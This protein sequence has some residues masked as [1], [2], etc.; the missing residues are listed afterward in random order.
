MPSPQCFKVPAYGA[1][2]AVFNGLARMEIERRAP[3]GDEVAIEILYC[4]VCHS[5]LHQAKNEWKNTIYPCVPGHEIVGR[6]ARVARGVKHFKTGDLVGVGCMIDSCGRCPSCRNGEENFCE[7]ETSFTGTYNGYTVPDGSGFNTFGGYS[8]HIV[9]REPFVV[10][11]PR[12]LDPA[13]AAPLLC[14]GVTTYSPLK[15]WKVGEKSQVAVVGL[16][17]LGHLAIKLAVALGAHVTGITSTERK[18]TA[19]LKLG[20]AQ[21]LNST[22]KHTFERH[23][24]EFDLVLN[25]IPDA[26]DVNDYVKLVKRDGTLVAVGLLTPFKTP[27]DNQEMVMQRRSLA[28]SLIGSMAE[29]REVLDFCARHRIAPDIEKIPIQEINRA[30]DRLHDNEVQFRYVIDMDSIRDDQASSVRQTNE[31]KLLASL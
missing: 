30:Y 11:I 16:G 13:A 10:L 12:Q 9:V 1:K 27:L 29:T 26:Y 14:A 20:A 22:K 7:G 28:G 17:G 21:I 6:V 2:G 18:R 31:T 19:A 15:H 3:R 25:T 5:D 8:S 4:G 24:A 23:E